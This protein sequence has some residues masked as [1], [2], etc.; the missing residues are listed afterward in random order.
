MTTLTHVYAASSSKGCKICVQ[1]NR[2]VACIRQSMDRGKASLDMRASSKFR[3]SPLLRGF[4]Y[5]KASLA[6]SSTTAKPRKLSV[7][8]LCQLQ[9]DVI[10]K[11]P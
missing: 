2:H 1:F 10:S 6:A 7:A 11:G 4:T 8:P 9:S 5:F 3:G